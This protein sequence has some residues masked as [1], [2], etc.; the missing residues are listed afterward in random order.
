MNVLLIG[1]GGREHAL[2]WKLKQSP[3]LEALYCAPGNAGIAEVAD[4]VA[5]DV[6][7][8]DAVA[9]FCRD[10]A[11]GLVVIGPEA[12]LVAG[13]ADDLEAPWHCRVRTVEGGGAARRLQGLHQGSLRRIRHP[14]RGLRPLQGSRARQV[15]CGR[16]TAARGHQGGRARRRQG[17]GDRQFAFRGLFGHRCLFHRRLRGSRRRGR[18]GGASQRRGGELLRPGGRRDRPAARHGARPQA[19][20]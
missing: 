5:L 15:P 19:R 3:L 20:A 10:K 6:A 12:P 14:D 4:C 16:A 17:R 11:I 18:G 9:Q 2:A 7:D 13:L 1:G 8:H